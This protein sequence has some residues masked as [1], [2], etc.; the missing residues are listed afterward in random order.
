MNL[1]NDDKLKEILPPKMFEI[2]KAVK[3]NNIHPNTLIRACYE[4]GKAKKN[5]RSASVT[6]ACGKGIEE[7][8]VVNAK[9][10]Q[11]DNLTE[12]I[13][14]AGVDEVDILRGLYLMAN[15]KRFTGWGSVVYLWQNKRLVQVVQEQRYKVE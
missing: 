15:I 3:E 9:T 6:I 8:V 11:S 5:K 14:C 10:K 4:L 2:L 1:S 7:L 13:K 12:A